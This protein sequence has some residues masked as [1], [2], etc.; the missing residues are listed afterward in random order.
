MSVILNCRVYL[1][2]REQQLGGDGEDPLRAIPYLGDIPG[3]SKEN[4]CAYLSVNT[5]WLAAALMV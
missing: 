3:S 5:H 2:N 4:V 1:N